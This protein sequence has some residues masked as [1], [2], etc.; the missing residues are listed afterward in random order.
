VAVGLAVGLP[1]VLIAVSGA[2]FGLLGHPLDLASVPGRLVNFLTSV[3]GYVRISAD[4]EVGF[5]P[6]PDV[7]RIA[8]A[9]IAFAAWSVFWTARMAQAVGGRRRTRLPSGSSGR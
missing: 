6:V 7:T 9:G 5:E 1:V 2:I 3:R 4:D 8:L